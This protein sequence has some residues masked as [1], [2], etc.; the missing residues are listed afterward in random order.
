MV[1]TLI[2]GIFPS[3]EMSP[4]VSLATCFSKHLYY[5]EFLVTWIKNVAILK[6][7]QEFTGKLL[8]PHCI[9]SSLKEQTWKTKRNQKTD[10]ATETEQWFT[11]NNPVFLW[12]SEGE[13]DLLSRVPLEPPELKVISKHVFFWSLIWTQHLPF[14]FLFEFFNLILSLK[15]IIMKYT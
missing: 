12:A 2:L 1:S 8:G 6:A 13:S 14:F 3:L 7:K 5:S 4:A 10:R 9:D 15:K 11:R